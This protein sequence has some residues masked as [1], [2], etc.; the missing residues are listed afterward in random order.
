MLRVVNSEYIFHVKLFG[1]YYRLCR[2]VGYSSVRLHRPRPH[3]VLLTG[4]K[5]RPLASEIINQST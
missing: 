1:N 3:Q 4:G 2:G 5:R